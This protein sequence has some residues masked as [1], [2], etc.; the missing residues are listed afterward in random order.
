V[1][2]HALRRRP[3]EHAPENF[4]YVLPDQ[5][6][7]QEAV[8]VELLSVAVHTVRSLGLKAR[9]SVVIMGSGTVG[10]LCVKV[11]RAFGAE[12]VVLCDVLTNKLEFARGYVD[13]CETFPLQSEC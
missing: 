4:V 12:S 9:E 5:I 10:L 1:G 3:S 2:R 13:G 7:L 8:L 11:A 6:S